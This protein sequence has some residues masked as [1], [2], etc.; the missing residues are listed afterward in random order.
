MPNLKE[1]YLTENEITTLKDIKDLP[2]L[3]T[4]N[5]NTNKLES[6][7]DLPDLPSL[8]VFDI[9]ANVIEKAGELPKLAGLRRLKTLVM[10]GN[11]WADEKGDDLKKEVLIALDELNIKMVNEDEVTAEDRNDAAEEKKTR[12]QAAKEAEEERLR[13]EAEKAAAGGAE[14]EA[15]EAE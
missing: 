1:L 5:V 8:E 6:L 13:E 7:D 3:K 14:G 2:N 4:L 10:A 9:G 15:E 12:I 11:P